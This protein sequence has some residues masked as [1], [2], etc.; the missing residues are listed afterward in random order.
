MRF[1][2]FAIVIISEYFFVGKRM[3]VSGYIANAVSH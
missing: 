1:A 2:M 3:C